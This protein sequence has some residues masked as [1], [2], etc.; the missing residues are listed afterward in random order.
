MA[1][2]KK[3]DEWEI[4]SAA[5]TLIEAEKIK[6]N[7]PLLKLARVELKRM[8]KASNEAVKAVAKK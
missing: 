7:K 1:K 6:N 8:A 5:S 2:K 4:E 3:Y